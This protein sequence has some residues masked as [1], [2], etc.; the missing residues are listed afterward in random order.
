MDLDT[1][2]IWSLRLTQCRVDRLIL[3]R[4]EREG[5]FVF[6]LEVLHIRGSVA[7]ADADYFHFALEIFSLLDCLVKFVHPERFLLARRSVPAENL[8]D[9][10]RGI[11]IRDSESAAA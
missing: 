1:D 10:N 8:N 5:D 3:I 4:K 6:L 9:N 11:D 2:E 7:N